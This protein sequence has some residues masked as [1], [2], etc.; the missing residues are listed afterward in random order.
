M[1]TCICIMYYHVKHL[2]CGIKS[3]F[4]VVKPPFLAAPGHSFPPVDAHPSCHQGICLLLTLGNHQQWKIRAFSGCK[5]R[6][7]PYLILSLIIFL[8]VFLDFL[9][10]DGSI[11]SWMDTYRTA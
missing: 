9:K 8:Y 5:Y 6:T 1:Y 7:S 10:I 11:D 2:F 3:L 4:S